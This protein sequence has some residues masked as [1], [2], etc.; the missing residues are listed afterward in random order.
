M[1]LTQ[2]NSNWL[3]MPT[4]DLGSSL[5]PPNRVQ[6][7]GTTL[8]KKHKIL[9]HP[10]SEP[11]R[12]ITPSTVATRNSQ[13][14]V[15]DTGTS[16]VASSETSSPRT[17]KHTSKR[18]ISLPPTPPT[19][20]RQSSGS[21]VA[22]R[23]DALF[24]SPSKIASV[25]STPTD[26]RSPPTPDVTPPRR[27]PPAFRPQV[28]DRYPSSRAESFKTALEDQ[29]SSDEDQVSTIRPVPAS[30]RTS[31]TAI[32]QVPKIPEVFQKRKEIGLGL[33]LESGNKTSS[34]PQPPES[35]SKDFHVFDGEWGSESGEVE[36]EWDDN[37][38]RN[39]TVRKR[40]G[41]FPPLYMSGAMEVLEDDIV[42]PTRAT[43]TVRNF[44]LQERSTPLVDQSQ[45][46]QERIARHRKQR[47]GGDR[48]VSEKYAQRIPWGSMDE[49]PVIPD[50]RRFSAMSSRSG[51]TVIGAIVVDAPLMRRRTLRHTKGQIG[52][53]DLGSDH[54]TLDLTPS[55][56]MSTEKV[57]LLHHSTGKISEN[58]HR[59]QQSNGT[60]SSNSSGKARRDVIRAGGIP[61][62]VIPDRRSSTKSSK[63]PSL[64]ST[65]SKK[66]KRSISLSSAPLSNSSKFNDPS[67]SEKLPPR[68]RT[69][70]ESACSGDSIRTIDFPPNI[71]VRR[72]SLSAPTSR[73]TSRAGSL[74]TE[75]LKAHDDI[76]SKIAQQPESKVATSY[77]STESH[78]ELGSHAS[79]P[80]FD[81]NGDPFFGKRLSTQVTPFSQLSYET[82]G[83]N[84]VVSEAMAVSLYPH[85][86]RSLLVVQHTSSE[87]SPPSLKPSESSQSAPP[88]MALNGDATTA[89]Y[90]PPQ[91]IHPM[92]EVDSPLKNPRVPPEP[93]AIKFIPATPAVLSPGEEEEK[94]LGFNFDEERPT[95]SDSKLNRGM[96][97]IRRFSRRRNSEPVSPPLP[98]LLKRT[99]SLS[100]RRKE[101][102]DESTQTARGN[103]NPST[104]YPSVEDQPADGSKLHPFW[105]PSHFWDDLEDEG[106]ADDEL[107]GGYPP[108]DNRPA[109]PK[110]S[111]SGKLKRTFAILPIQ[112]DH[113]YQSY[114]KDRRILRKS[115][116]GNLRV[117]KQRSTS[118]LGRRD[119]NRGNYSTVSRPRE[120][121]FGYG[122]QEGNRGN[123]VHT[124]PGIGVR[125]EY[126]GWSAVKQKFSERRRLQRS[127]KLRASI[128]HPREVQSGVD[129]VLRRRRVI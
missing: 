63:P 11:S 102:M 111:L 21:Y 10:R 100:T 28:I 122:F 17:L 20:S 120:G 41:K 48:S 57:H 8:L 82:A 71:P 56:V 44:P 79:R 107:T 127:E 106:F 23:Q 90:T 121:S 114:S 103:A 37:L 66:T 33:S 87:T 22:N 105:R 40:P 113:Q 12:D 32:P 109:P 24:R 30:A 46:L 34:S 115:N 5:D 78:K 89:P 36:R 62:V 77:R 128:S 55:S 101:Q 75:S 80:N 31:A 123:R 110:R 67:Y 65:S 18:I 38:M 19:H 96:S 68:R 126:V 91:P 85:Q 50:V 73:N 47:D 49:S 94:Q 86:N 72:S 83:T 70:S 29:D 88:S 124:I 84:P 76:Q 74:T 116:S 60:I 3:R 81:Q 108:I 42:S 129:D 119:I 9:P 112:D 61:V 53:R 64:R 92:D 6:S 117:V 39:V 69:M 27:I 1:L 13:N 59:S 54:S 58:R 118:S 51:S 14:L 43:R 35:P 97:L 52:L 125:V 2:T 93:P 25:P 95:T 16:S 104:L 45:P 7:A 4:R 15:I 26:Q 98:G 99:F